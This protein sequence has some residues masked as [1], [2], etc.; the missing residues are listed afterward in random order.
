MLPD[1]FEMPEAQPVP[2]RTY[3]S[4]VLANAIPVVGVIAFG[5]SLIVLVVYYWI[6]M[7]LV[8][9]LNTPK[10][11]LAWRNTSPEE[12]EETPWKLLAGYLLRYVGF[13]LIYAV[14][15]GVFLI[16]L[17]TDPGWASSDY[18]QSDGDPTLLLISVALGIVLIIGEEVVSI[19]S[20][21]EVR[22]RTAR[23]QANQP[24]Y[25]L[26]DP[27]LLFFLAIGVLIF[28]RSLTVLIIIIAFAKFNLDVAR[29][30]GRSKT[31]FFEEPNDRN[32][33]F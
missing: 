17:D 22:Q 3:I 21:D 4:L 29:A 2:L 25:R 33:P 8:G 14:G 32:S 13:A 9:L 24:A 27:L 12:I 16:V 5:W 1:D 20:D 30:R 26:I 31:T 10:I 18:F 7:V 11:Y 6:E 23:Q 28:S 19:I 15:F